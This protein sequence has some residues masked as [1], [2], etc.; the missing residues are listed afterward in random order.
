LVV[1]SGDGA[2]D[3]EVPEDTLDPVAFPI[4]TFVVADHSFPVRLRRDNSFDAA[5]LQVGPDG[6]RI[7]RFIGQERL[8]FLF[9]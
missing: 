4:E 8:G 2:V 7:V 1:S 5:P 6:I 3:F 9:G